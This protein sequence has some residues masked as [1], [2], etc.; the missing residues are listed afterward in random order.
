MVRLEIGKDEVQLELTVVES[1]AAFSFFCLPSS[2]ITNIKSIT[3]HDNVWSQMKGIRVGTG[4]PYSIM[5]GMKVYWEGKDFVAVYYN[6]PG[7]VIELHSGAYK[8]WIISCTNHTEAAL[9]LQQ[10]LDA[11]APAPVS[12]S[13]IGVL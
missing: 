13:D 11:L 2:A 1:I 10:R 12:E 5:F 7:V 8:R 9:E 4:V 6:T 3:T